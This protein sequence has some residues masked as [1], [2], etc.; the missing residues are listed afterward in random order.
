[1]SSFTVAI[2]ADFFTAFAGLPRQQ[3]ARVRDFITKFRANPRSPGINYEKI[4]NAYDPNMYSVRIDDTYR[5]IVVRQERSGVYLLL[6]I[7]HHDRAY[8]WA[9]RKRCKVHPTTGTVQVFDVQETV[10]TATDQ[11]ETDK[12][13]FGHVTDEQLLRLGVP[14]EKLPETRALMTLEDLYQRKAS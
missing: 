13:L 8:D 4:Q 11:I 12:G 6:W 7:D 10:V 5:G 9:C 3:Q 14:S 1:M 2:S